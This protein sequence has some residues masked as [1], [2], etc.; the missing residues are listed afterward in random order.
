MKLEG[1]FETFSLRELIDI[2]IYSSVTGVL[3][4][5]GAGDS[6]HLY[7]R[8]SVLYHV[9]R[10]PARGV[11]ALGE[12]FELREAS[13]SFV[14]DAVVDDQTLYGSVEA[15]VLAAQELGIRWR[16]IRT[17]VPRLDLVCRLVVAPELAERCI[18]PRHLP[19]LAVVDGQ[20]T[21][22]Q[23][24]ALLSWAEIDVAEAAA[25]MSGDG[26]V[27]LGKAFDAP[28]EQPRNEP[29]TSGGGLFDRILARAQVYDAELAA[30][31][32][33]PPS[34]TAEEQILRV[35]RGTG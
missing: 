20:R 31:E 23:I 24:A 16:S 4:I 21:L 9:E 25:E 17:H 2:V 29:Q 1:T 11:E 22:R 3:N 32:Y 27:A 28:R 33:A 35:L 15:H 13:F 14:S 30:S 18:H 34:N 12:L 6:G 10:G 26:V 7:F 5:F 8:N 19:M